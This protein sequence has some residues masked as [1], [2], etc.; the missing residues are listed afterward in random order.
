MTFFEIT[1]PFLKTENV[2]P[3]KIRMLKQSQNV[4]KKIVLLL[5]GTKNMMK[6]LQSPLE[7]TEIFCLDGL[8]YTLT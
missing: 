2:I 4:T 3:S 7:L 1:V 8:L 6:K 5:S